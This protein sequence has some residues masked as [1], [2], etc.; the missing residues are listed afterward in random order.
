MYLPTK[1]GVLFWTD[2]MLIQRN[3]T[4]KWRKRG[5]GRRRRPRRQGRCYFGLS[6]VRY[7][8]MAYAHWYKYIAGSLSVLVY[9]ENWTYRTKNLLFG[10]LGTTELYDNH[11]LLHKNNDIVIFILPSPFAD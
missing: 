3:G 11:I 8:G 6:R 7:K 9:G 10:V 1:K 5:T 2:F 4:M